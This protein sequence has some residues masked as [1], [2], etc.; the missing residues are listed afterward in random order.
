TP[1]TSI[2]GYTEV[3]IRKMKRHN[4]PSLAYMDKIDDQL[5]KVINMI[6]DL[7]DISTRHSGQVELHVEPL[8]V[9]TIITQA[10]EEV[11]AIAHKHRIDIQGNLRVMIEGDRVR[12]GQVM[13]NLI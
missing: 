5:T 3:V 9:E 11:Q 13:V 2:K 10:V 12:L 4:D 6:R 7:L 1:L 8:S